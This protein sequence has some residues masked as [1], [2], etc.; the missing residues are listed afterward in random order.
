[1][2][3]ASTHKSTFWTSCDRLAINL[4]VRTHQQSSGT[5]TQISGSRGL[6]TKQKVFRSVRCI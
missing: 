4:S 2:K 5:T 1:M 6:K 3:F